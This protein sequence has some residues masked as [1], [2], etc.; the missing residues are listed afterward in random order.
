[1]NRV[2]KFIFLSIGLLNCFMTIAQDNTSYEDSVINKIN[3]ERGVDRINLIIDE[4][5][6]YR[7]SDEIFESLV[8]KGLNLSNSLD[9]N[10]QK[11]MIYFHY[12]V[13]F[14]F[15]GN[16][17][18]Q[19]IYSDMGVKLAVQSKDPV[20]LNRM[21]TQ[22]AGQGIVNGANK[23]AIEN[24]KR[25]L[26][27][28]DSTDEFVA[29]AF[30][31]FHIANFYNNQK[32]P[33]NALTFLPE[34]MES[35]R[36]IEKDKL[37]FLEAN[38]LSTYAWSFLLKEDY[39]KCKDYSIQ[40]I[41]LIEGL[42]FQSFHVK[43]ILGWLY[44]NLG[45]S[46][47]SLGNVEKAVE[48]YNLAYQSFQSIGGDYGLSRIYIRVGKLYF[49][50]G[51]FHKSIESLEKAI[52]YGEDNSELE[53][54]KDAY[55]LLAKVNGEVKNYSSS[56]KYFQKYDDARDSLFNTEA[57]HQMA[58]FQTEFN[59]LQ[60]E[61]ENILLRKEA[62]VKQIQLKIAFVVAFILIAV[63]IVIALLYIQIRKTKLALEH[64]NSVISE[65]SKELD[66]LN[67]AKDKLFAI[68]SHDLRGH[69]TSF[70]GIGEI[71]NYY[72]DK[73][74]NKKIRNITKSIDQNANQLH[75]LLDNVLHWSVMEMK[76]TTLK[77]KEINLNILIKNMI[78]LY[79]M[80]AKSKEISLHSDL[81][82]KIAIN[83]DENALNVIFRNFI[84][85]AIKFTPEQGNININAISVEDNVIISFKDSGIGMDESKTESLFD[86]QNIS[87]VLGTGGEQGIGLG[88]KLSKHFIDNH[89]GRIDVES[90][91]GQGTT[92][93]ITMPLV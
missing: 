55:Y 72:L 31:L 37:P 38:V 90:E 64:Q 67:N 59:T 93:S 58:K 1:M 39:E 33:D 80:S 65:K 4:L 47:L 44:N 29:K 25:A 61:N 66:K 32:Q 30:T 6:R 20:V 74:E 81:K 51:N 42:S 8:E 68:V 2:I 89:E 85:N 83:A 86:T 71:I 3:K 23:E 54:V 70:S 57:N 16:I 26:A 60:K 17:K 18:E 48:S 82:E 27:V 13:F 9:L 35:I 46:Y 43:R 92:F 62:E 69:I 5:E 77:K 45:E 10:D 91:V 12:S 28:V 41:E 11:A 49:E 22:L 50:E 87:S 14:Y 19:A 84:S 40:G 53:D 7:V 75:N 36:N 21:Y 34:A 76:E 15:K 88:L 56:Y 63:A 52:K 78:K 24:Y 79:E 73:K